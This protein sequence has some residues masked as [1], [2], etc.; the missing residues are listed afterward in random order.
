MSVHTHTKG[1]MSL[2]ITLP[3]ILKLDTQE[4]ASLDTFMCWQ[5][6]RR[7]AGAVSLTLTRMALYNT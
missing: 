1:D 6:Q 7:A 4:W 2:Q 3:G 5:N